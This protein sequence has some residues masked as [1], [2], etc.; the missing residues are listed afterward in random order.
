M[1]HHQLTSFSIRITHYIDTL[2]EQPFFRSARNDNAWIALSE[3][4]LLA[5]KSFTMEVLLDWNPDARTWN[6]C[7]QG[8]DGETF[9]AAYSS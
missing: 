6:A 8:V 4:E 7:I 3:E 9:R 5:E 2:P 1:L